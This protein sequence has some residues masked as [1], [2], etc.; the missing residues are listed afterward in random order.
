MS[1]VLKM[2]SSEKN[3]AGEG[4]WGV[5]IFKTGGLGTAHGSDIS[6]KI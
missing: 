1:S 4:T 5:S 2:G 6:G 3:Q